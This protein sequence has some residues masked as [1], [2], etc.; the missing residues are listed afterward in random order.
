[1]YIPVILGTG[2][3]SRRSKDVA[4]FV[5]EEVRKKGIETE[6]IDVKDYPIDFT[7]GLEK[8]K[9]QAL[10]EKFFRAEGFIIVA[11]E[12]NHSYPGE[13][14]LLLDNF[15]KEYNRKPIGFCGVTSGILGGSRAVEQLKLIS[16]ELQMAPIREALYFSRVQDLFDE[17][18]RI[19]DQSHYQW[20]EKFLEELLWF[21]KALKTARETK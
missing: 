19:K 5:L 10:S 1:M 3:E 4:N 21:A 18:G 15:Y 8:R 13:L 7:G 16:I 9:H 2:R 12:Y 14:K 6:L 20:V 11:P 17:Q